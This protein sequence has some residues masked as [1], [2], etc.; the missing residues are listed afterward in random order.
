MFV[1]QAY[2]NIK[3]EDVHLNAY[4]SV[5]HARCSIGILQSSMR[6]AN[7]AETDAYTYP[8]DTAP[9]RHATSA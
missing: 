3:Y 2:H 7:L 8:A 1:K 4:E 9:H 6:R 5:S